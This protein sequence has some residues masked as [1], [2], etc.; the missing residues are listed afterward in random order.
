ML[1]ALGKNGDEGEVAGRSNGVEMALGVAL[2]LPVSPPPLPA[3][4]APA[5]SDDVCEDTDGGGGANSAPT[6]NSPSGPS[7]RLRLA[8]K[9]AGVV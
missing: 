4:D 8:A 6:R 7:T 2:L 5:G 9:L 1:R 3:A